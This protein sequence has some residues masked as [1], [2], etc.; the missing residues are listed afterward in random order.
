MMTVGCLLA[1]LILMVI[2]WRSRPSTAGG[3]LVGTYR[4]DL[5]FLSFFCVF[6]FCIYIIFFGCASI[7]NMCVSF[8]S[9]VG[10][11]RPEGKPKHM[12]RSRV[13]DAREADWVLH[14]VERHLDHLTT[15]V[16]MAE[17]EDLP[18]AY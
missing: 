14:Q 10:P 8:G 16:P 5:V 3:C 17:I 2:E 15:I 6:V 4:Y 9:D 7:I 11:V 18:V 12:R 1:V 13:P